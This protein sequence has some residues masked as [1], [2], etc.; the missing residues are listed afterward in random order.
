MIKKRVGFYLP[1]ASF[2]NVD[3]RNLRDGNPGIGGSEYALLMI[4][5]EL[6]ERDNGIEI[7]VFAEDVNNYLP[8]MNYIQVAHL[9]E[10]IAQSE[11]SGMDILVFK[12]G[13]HPF[14]CLEKISS[15]LKIVVWCHNF[16]NLEKL[17]YLAKNKSVA[18]IICVGR[19]QLDMYRDHPAFLKSDYIYNGVY[20]DSDDHD[21]MPPFTDRPEWV[22]YIG[23]IIPAKG[24]HYLL[25]NWKKVIRKK[26]DAQL[27]IIGSGQLYNRNAKLGKYGIAE[28]KYE[29][30]FINFILEDGKIMP[31][32]HFHGIMGSEKDEIL[33]KTK[34]GCPNPSGQTETYGFTAVEMQMAGAHIVTKKC[35]GY[36]DTVNPRTGKLYANVSKLSKMIITELNRKDDDYESTFRFIA[37]KFSVDIIIPQWEELLGE[38]ISTGEK[39]HDESIVNRNFELKWLKES[40]RKVKAKFPVLYTLMPSYLW[41][42]NKLVRLHL[43]KP[44]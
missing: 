17:N 23:S 39:L 30:S 27:H 2:K 37:S 11:A 18:R 33:R 9:P 24:V 6:H 8:E 34:V 5:H 13:I 28:E 32:V 16:M 7:T 10:A 43:I 41:W 19:E 20:T 29:D 1:N 40:L 12:G 15:N 25:K 14:S 21:Q 31:S 36:L 3:C 4:S 26:P 38:K 42:R 22:T 44:V 35:C